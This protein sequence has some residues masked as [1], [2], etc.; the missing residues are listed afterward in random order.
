MGK[1]VVAETIQISI[2]AHNRLLTNATD[3]TARGLQPQ[4][5]TSFG[6]NFADA[7]HKF[8]DKGMDTTD[9]QDDCAILQQ[10]IEMIVQCSYLT[11]QEGNSKLPLRW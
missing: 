5:S 6:L 10:L 9:I 2:L 4:A 3:A 7:R 11:Q 8:H 1:C